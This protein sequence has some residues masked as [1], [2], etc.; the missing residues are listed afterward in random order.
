M[1]KTK[2]WSNYEKAMDRRVKSKAGRDTPR[3]K[4]LSEEATAYWNFAGFPPKWVL[5][6]I[7]F[8]YSRAGQ[9]KVIADKHAREKAVA[10][11]TAKERR[12]L[13]V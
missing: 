7:R 1:T 8:K 10:K 12:L 5:D 9:R 2:G 11:L 13:G 6:Q 4:R 3:Y